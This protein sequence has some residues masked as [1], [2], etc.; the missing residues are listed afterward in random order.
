MDEE[1][2]NEFDRFSLYAWDGQFYWG[3]EAEAL[4]S[5]VWRYLIAVKEE[6]I[7]YYGRDRTIEAKCTRHVSEVVK[8]M[9]ALSSGPL[10]E[11][12]VDVDIWMYRY[13]G[14]RM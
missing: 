1:A 11:A 10:V 6:D 7:K 2:E 5:R 12:D 3:V 13:Y 9:L 14:E 4:S 8:G